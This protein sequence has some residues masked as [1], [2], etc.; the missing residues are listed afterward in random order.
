LTHSLWEMV[1]E[2]SQKVPE[3]NVV[4]KSARELDLHYIPSRHP[5]GLPDGY[6]H[7]FY[8]REMA[9]H[10]LQASEKIVS[11]VR[12]FFKTQGAEE[13]ITPSATQ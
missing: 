9:E 3:L 7:V 13:I 4:A 8:D 2:G 10:A 12:E 1:R 6:P 5:N 11:V